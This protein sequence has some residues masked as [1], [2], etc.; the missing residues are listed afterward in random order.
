MLGLVVGLLQ[1][2]IFL[3]GAPTLIGAMGAG[4]GSPMRPVALSY[5]RVRALGMPTATMWLVANGIFRGLGDT[6]TPLVWALLFS[7]LNALLDPIFIF[8]LGAIT[9]WCRGVQK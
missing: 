6:R 2:V 9:G 7:A 1:A 5:L 8:P 3:V 4:V